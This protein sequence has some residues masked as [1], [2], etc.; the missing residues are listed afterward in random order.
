MKLSKGTNNCIE[1][2]IAR[3]IMT[4]YRFSFMVRSVSS[5]Q[6]DQDSS[7]WVGDSHSQEHIGIS[8]TSKSSRAI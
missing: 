1:F 4:L 5:S 3:L 7:R 6:P 8:G 2:T